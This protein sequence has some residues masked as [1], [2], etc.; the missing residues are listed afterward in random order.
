MQLPL[1]DKL[2]NSNINFNLDLL[3]YQVKKNY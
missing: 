2:V 1:K 3:S